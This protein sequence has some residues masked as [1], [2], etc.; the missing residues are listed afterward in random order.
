MASIRKAKK[1]G[2]YKKPSFNKTLYRDVK[3]Q[4]DKV[5]KRLRQLE[6]TGNYNSYASKKLFNRLDTETLKALEKTRKGK[7]IKA[8]KIPKNLTQTQLIAIQKATKQFLVSKTSST[9]GI[10]QVKQSTIDAIKRTMSDEDA[11]KVTDE[12]AKF[13]FDMLGDND[14]DYFADKIGASTLWTLIDSAIVG[15]YTQDRWLKTLNNYINFEND[16]DVR[17]RA[18]RLF[19]KYVL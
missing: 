2:I 15:N 12:D 10:K 19:E 8:V 13:Y 14:F 9:K 3:M 1:L 5:N 18:I 6:K 7:I 11:K 17:E 4:V 16:A